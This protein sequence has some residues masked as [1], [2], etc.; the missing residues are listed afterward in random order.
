MT[1]HV[2][3]KLAERACENKSITAFISLKGINSG[4]AR[5]DNMGQREIKNGDRTGSVF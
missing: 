5:D 1:N 3:S 2:I 4:E